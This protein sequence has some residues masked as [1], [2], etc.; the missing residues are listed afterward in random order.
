MRRPSAS[1]VADSAAGA[2][3]AERALEQLVKELQ[4]VLVSQTDGQSEQAAGLPPSW[5][6]SP[7]QAPRSHTV[8]VGGVDASPL[9]VDDDQ[10]S[11]VEELE[12]EGGSR[13][14]A[15]EQA[16]LLQRRFAAVAAAQQAAAQAAA[17]DPGA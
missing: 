17:R 6:L 2:S 5:I 14:G 7:A 4:S 8:E 10:E 11:E 9:Y 1:G 12:E 3:Y 16:A 15:A 13:G